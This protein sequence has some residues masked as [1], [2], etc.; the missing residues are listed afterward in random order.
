MPGR[1]VRTFGAIVSYDTVPESM[2]TLNPPKSISKRHEL[3]EDK[4]VTFY[5]RAWQFVDENRTIVYA[6]VAGFVVLVAAIIGY[7]V[8]QNAQAAEAEGMLAQIIPVYEQGSLQQALD[9]TGDRLGLLEIADEYGGTAAGNL[10]HFYAADALFNMGEYDRALEHFEAF[11]KSA[12]FIG[13]SAYA[14]EAAV[15][16]SREEYERAGDLYRRAAYHF[17]N[18]LTSPEYLM[19]AGR[20][21]ELG[22]LYDEAL[23]QYEAVQTEYP[24]SA[25]AS[26]IEVYLARA[27]AKQNS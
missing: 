8:Y 3:R 27:A 14:G 18:D 21:Y 17:E 22:G 23:A 1:N 13:A 9:G 2:S 20:A 15:Y 12:D 24:E 7:V 19:N 6:A 5:A 16:E 11:D 25:Q 26:R 10:A 4:V